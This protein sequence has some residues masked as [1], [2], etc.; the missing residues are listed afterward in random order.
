MTHRLTLASNTSNL[1]YVEPFL[2]Q[3]TQELGLSEDLYS[4]CVIALTEAVNNGI[5]HG[6][7]RDGSKSVLIE[8]SY[9]TPTLTM[10]VQDEGSGFDPDSLPDPT[11]PANLLLDGGRGVL[12][13]RALM[14]RARFTTIEGGSQT[15]LEL[16][17]A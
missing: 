9:A 4:N 11:D 8:I 12:I 3:C 14:S 2:R 17:Y 13:I 15:W 7:K 10:L 16:D 6:N 5:V 1:Q